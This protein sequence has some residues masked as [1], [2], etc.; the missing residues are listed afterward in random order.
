MLMWG[1]DFLFVCLPEAEFQ[2]GI[3]K[4]ADW[5]FL[6]REQLA[7]MN[8]YCCARKEVIGTFAPD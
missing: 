3:A 2:G 1:W 6:E 7:K 8:G 5:V 4:L